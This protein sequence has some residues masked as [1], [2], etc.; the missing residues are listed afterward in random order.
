MS[1]IIVSDLTFSYDTS[2]DNIFEHVNFMIDTDW[3]LGFIGRNGRGKTTFLNLLLG[4]YEYTG[5]ITTSVDFD[6]FPFEVLD[7]GLETIQIIKDTVAPFTRWEKEMDECLL[8]IEEG[9][10]RKT[11]EATEKYGVIQEIYQAHDGYIIEELIEKEL[12]T[13]KVDL[14]VLKRPFSTLSFGE[15]TKI[16]L[17]A[18]FLKKNNFLLIDEPTNHLDMEGREILGDYLQSKKGFILVSHD[19]AFLDRIIDHVLSINLT[20]IEVQKGNYSSWQHNKELQDHYELDKNEQLRK[21]IVSLQTAAKRTLGWSDKI[22]ATKIGTH[23]ADRGAIGHKS[24]KMMKRA[25]SIEA[26]QLNAIEEKQGLLKNIEK[27]DSLKL[28]L[29]TFPKDRIIEAEDIS[30][31]YEDRKIA[32][33]INFILKKGE[34]IALKGKNGSGKSTLIKLM[35]GDN[36]KYTGRYYI[37]PNIKISYVSQDTS[38]LSGNL[39]DFAV[40]YGLDET[41]FKTVLR[42]LDFSREQFEKD[43]QEFSGGQ[44]KKV[45]LAKSLSQ[46]AHLFIWDEPFNFIDVLS[47]VQIEELILKYEP[48]MIFVEHDKIFSERIATKILQ[49]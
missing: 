37:A 11:L 24:A 26:R 38:Y 23:A 33:S 5:N 12:S 32:S 21:D 22:E 47:R 4:K 42:Q 14:S 36:I 28:N 3:K 34:R 48:T 15:R 35:L 41:I 6:Y 49:M 20:N 7:E 16:M 30:L 1:Q 29:L 27:A 39:K 19:R 18:L 17:A 25:K 9:D 31:F 8:L 13:L 43:I 45:L 46:P 44:K 10:S 40:Q 2:Y